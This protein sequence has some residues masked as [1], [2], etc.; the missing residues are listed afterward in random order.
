MRRRATRIGLL[1]IA[2]GVTMLFTAL[3]MWQLDRAEQ[4]RATF[5]EF[6]RRGHA[7]IVDLNRSVDDDAALPGYRATAQGHYIGA[8]ILLDNQVHRGRAGYLVYSV[9]ELDGREESMLV[10]RGWINTGADRSVAP[11]LATP[12]ISQKLAGRLSLPPQGGLRLEGSDMI[13]PLTADLW[14][15]QAIDFVALTKTLGLELLPIT[16][17]LHSDAPHG[18]VRAWTPPATDENRHLGYAF[19]WFALAVTVVVVTLVV[20]LRGDKAGS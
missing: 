11:K 3:G 18:F 20:T 1:A 15:V 16:L 8:T 14:R 4:K 2:T 5:S 10:N 7:S 6:E 13:E 9:F 12:T 19:Q 17:L